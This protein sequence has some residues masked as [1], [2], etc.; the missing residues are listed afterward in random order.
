MSATAP[1]T[2]LSIYHHV[3]ALRRPR[4]LRTFST[5]VPLFAK[6]SAFAKATSTFGKESGESSSFR[7]KSLAKK[8]V[9]GQ[10]RYPSSILTLLSWTHVQLMKMGI[11][12]N[13]NLSCIDFM[14]RGQTYQESPK[15]R[16]AWWQKT[17]GTLLIKRSAS[18]ISPF[19][20]PRTKNRS[21]LLTAIMLQ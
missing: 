12:Y 16:V 13:T 17:R 6:G 10:E 18:R 11:S 7:T 20:I 2:R 3:H 14:F 15:A 9:D 4:T 8:I 1:R 19:Y 5:N 21:P